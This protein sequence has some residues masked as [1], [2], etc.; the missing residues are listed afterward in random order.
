MKYELKTSNGA[1]ISVVCNDYEMVGFVGNAEPISQ[2]TTTITTSTTKTTTTG[3]TT[4]LSC[5]CI[6]KSLNML[7][8]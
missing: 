7:P 2:T 5:N 3:G 4:R 8:C 1:I 6:E